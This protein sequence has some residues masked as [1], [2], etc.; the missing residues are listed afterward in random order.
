MRLAKQ[1][2][3]PDDPLA[4][5]AR[6]VRNE[7]ISQ[8]RASQR[9]LRREQLAATWH[10]AWFEPPQVD[11]VALSSAEV[12]TALRQLDEAVRE[13]LVAHIWGG[14]TFR[15]IAD[16]FGMPRST[17]H[18]RYVTALEQLRGR[19]GLPLNELDR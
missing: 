13:V 1:L 6:V 12:E 14:L 3:V 9:R 10:A 17:V 16:A 4:W 8:A 7:A 2:P 18:R 5:L 11:A 19:L 15:Q